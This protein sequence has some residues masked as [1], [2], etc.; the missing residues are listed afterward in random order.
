M[1][2]NGLYGATVTKS[3]VGAGTVTGFSDRG[4]P[5]VNGVAVAWA[6]FSDGAVYD[7]FDQ[8]EKIYRQEKAAAAK[9]VVDDD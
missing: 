6:V 7:P 3:P 8:Y 5:Q 4:I 1:P 2:K 9:V